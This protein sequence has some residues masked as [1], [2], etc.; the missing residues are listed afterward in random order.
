MRVRHLLD[1]VVGDVADPDAPRRRG[2]DVEVVD[3]DTRCGDDTK[4][5]QALEVGRGD[6]LPGTERDDVIPLP[7][8]ARELD[9]DVEP[10]KLLAKPVDSHRR[11]AEDA[12]H[13]QPRSAAQASASS[14]FSRSM[15]GRGP[16]VMRA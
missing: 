2:V 10:V 12:C 15:R 6:G 14:A 16:T 4:R 3:P 8:R 11:V 13:D 9:D 5:R 7:R 1:A